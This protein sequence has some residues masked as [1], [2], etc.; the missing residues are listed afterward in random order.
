ME[1]TTRSHLE[2]ALAGEAMAALRYHLFAE[3]AEEEGFRG[4]AAL[5]E[6]IGSQERR[7]H[8]AEIAELLGLVGTTRENLEM[9]LAGEVSEHHKVYPTYASEAHRAGD[10]E[11]AERFIELGGDEHRHAELIRE[12]I[13]DLDAL[14]VGSS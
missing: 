10:E 2:A 4:I 13:R 14:R 11:A 1:S 5:F 9:A 3:R 6:E 12:A 8:F 7:E